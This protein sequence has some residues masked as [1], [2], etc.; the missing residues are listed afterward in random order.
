[1][2][3]ISCVFYI[4]YLFFNVYWFLHML[5]PTLLLHAITQIPGVIAYLPVDYT[6][7]WMSLCSYLAVYNQL[8]KL[9]MGECTSVLG[10]KKSAAHRRVGVLQIAFWLSGKYMQDLRF[11][12]RMRNFLNLMLFL[13]S[14]EGNSL[15]TVMGSKQIWKET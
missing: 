11:L 12:H 1:M 7:N 4:T 15:H 9:T 13:H 14:S 10:Q 2:R 3:P 5:K 8:K 6:T